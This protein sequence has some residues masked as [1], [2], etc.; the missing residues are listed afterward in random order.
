[1]RVRGIDRG[2]ERVSTTGNRHGWVD[3]VEPFGRPAVEYQLEG[4]K[5]PGP[6]REVL[7]F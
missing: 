4:W 2:L 6:E 3:P 7:D 5:V 1:V